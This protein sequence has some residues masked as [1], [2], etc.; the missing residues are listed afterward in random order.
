MDR[1]ATP[2]IIDSIRIE[3][4][5]IFGPGEMRRF[6]WIARLANGVHWLTRESVVRRELLLHRGDPYD[7]ALAA[8]TERN[9]RALRLFSRVSV[10]AESLSTGGVLLRVRTQDR[11]TLR[12][13]ASYSLEGGVQEWRLYYAE[14]NFLGRALR[15]RTEL[16]SASNRHRRL[17][18]SVSYED[19]RFLGRRV[20]TALEYKDA[21]DLLLR[22]IILGHPFLRESQP[23]AGALYFD[24]GWA[25]WRFYRDGIVL[26]EQRI[27]LQNF[28]GW[29]AV[30]RGTESKRSIALGYT[31][32]RD[33][34]PEEAR[35]PGDRMDL[36]TLSAS[37]T[38]RK[39][40]KEINL[41]NLEE[42]EDVPLGIRALATAGINVD[43]RPG[44]ADGYGRTG[45]RYVAGGA[46]SPYTALSLDARSFLLERR[47][48]FAL[49]GIDGLHRRRLPWNQTLILRARGWLGK[50]WP[51]GQQLALG[52]DTGL[53]GFPQNQFTGQ[54]LALFNIEDRSGALAHWWIFRLG[55]VLFADAGACWDENESFRRQRWHASVGA[56]LRLGNAKSG[57][58]GLLRV[59]LPFRLDDRSFP[60]I[61]I[62]SDQ[63]FASVF[64][65]DFINP[66]PP[67]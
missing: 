59:D 38:R 54:R 67:R 57:G 50:N 31:R 6:P 17:G 51:P 42:I 66:L 35:T 18:T 5:Q 1:P 26:R 37:L 44:F 45:L 29:L 41:D 12:I 34:A 49:L 21:D 40:V 63:L 28:S 53:R 4:M 13:G 39:F 56:G 47:L 16:N 15:I 33:R 43:R 32:A 27:D 8:E 64:G 55:T 52:S 9:L 24:G 60:E 65:L 23:W 61:I 58:S 25:L 36:L 19:P 48:G 2:G 20:Y 22:R 3:R 11:H 7:P 30:S 62:T 14:R 10:T 46:G